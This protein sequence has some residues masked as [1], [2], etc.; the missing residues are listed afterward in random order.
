MKELFQNKSNSNGPNQSRA[1]THNTMILNLRNYTM[2]GVPTP[3]SASSTSYYYYNNNKANDQQY[4]VPSTPA[5]TDIQYMSMSS[6][7]GAMHAPT[8]SAAAGGSSST[9]SALPVK[10]STIRSRFK[11][12]SNVSSIST[13][14]SASSNQQHQQQ[15]RINSSSSSS[16][17]VYFP[18]TNQ[19]FSINSRLLSSNT[20]NTATP[21]SQND[22]INVADLQSKSS[23]SFYNGSPN[24]NNT[25]SNNN[26]GAKS[27]SGTNTMSSLTLY[28]YLLQANKNLAKEMKAS[29]IRSQTK[30]LNGTSSTHEDEDAIVDTMNSIGTRNK[31]DSVY[32]S[33]QRFK[34]SS[35]LVA[36]LNKQSDSSNMAPPQPSSSQSYNRCASVVDTS[37]NSPATSIINRTTKNQHRLINYKLINSKL[38]N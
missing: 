10:A 38:K 21:R 25:T 36:N 24:S 13:I 2:T 17:N 27:K 4:N 37:L 12:K 15:Q 28:A 35:Q 1:A 23:L 22:L 14:N 16:S 29:V 8:S 34:T 20:P 6:V 9:P 19:Y 3:D 7:N 30:K 11:N 18:S 33:M 26:N 32:T 31:H 5:S